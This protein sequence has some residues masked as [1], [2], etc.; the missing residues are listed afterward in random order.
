MSKAFMDQII[1]NYIISKEEFEEIKPKLMKA[2]K[3]VAR[4]IETNGRIIFP[5]VG[6]FYD[7]IKGMSKD[8]EYNCKL[9]PENL[10]PLNAGS[11]YMN[12]INE[13][14]EMGDSR[15][16]GVL[17]LQSLDIQSDDVII[18]MTSSGKTKYVIGSVNFTG[19][20][21]KDT[22]LLTNTPFSK[23]KSDLGEE[24]VI[25][26]GLKNETSTMRSFDGSTLIKIMVDIIFYNALE[27]SGRI[28]KGRS[29]FETW[30]SDHQK[31]SVL[32]TIQIVSGKSYE[33]SEKILGEAGYVSHI[34][35]V[36]AIRD[37]DAE[38]A[39]KLLLEHRNNFKK[40]AN[41]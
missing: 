20:I 22:F 38:T 18:G 23:Q 40:I 3:A 13:W 24:N 34:A 6:L 35:N 39:A 14:K 16:A 19:V 28:Y 4:Q 36:M 2:S 26:L 11:L 12:E 41:A 7:Y 10:I 8:W 25:S 21:T 9:N 27:I 29:I 5:A 32:E 33:E 37:C 31:E 1:E 17:E 30:N 15:Q